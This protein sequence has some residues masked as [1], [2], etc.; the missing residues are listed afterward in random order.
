[1]NNIDYIKKYSDKSDVENNLKRLE[2]GE[3]P[4]Y[5]LGSTNFYG[6][7]FIVNENV[8]IPRF[9]TEILIEKTI[10]Y[11]DKYNI[12]NPNILDIGTGSG[13]IA[14]TFKKEIECNVTASDIS[15]KALNIAT[16]NAKENNT[17]IKFIESNVFNNINDKYD[18]IISNP[19]YIGIDEEVESIVK[20]NEPHIALYAD[21]NGLSIYKNIIE[22]SINYINDKAIIAFEIGYKQ[23]IEIKKIAE[24][25][26]PKSTITI[27]KDLSGKDRYVFIFINCE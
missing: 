20:N 2:N 25:I 15:L 21:E 9:E 12:K 3:P 7:D 18:L 19:P 10:N 13:A 22:N 24:K 4:Q 5:I 17:K 8:L 27:E 6:Y 26:Y 14:V 11:L 16:V 1:M 23:G